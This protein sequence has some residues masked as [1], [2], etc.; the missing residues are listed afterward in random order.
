MKDKKRKQNL[1]SNKGFISDEARFVLVGLLIFLLSFIGIIESGGYLGK[2]ISFIFVYLFGVF[3]FIPLILIGIY[4]LYIFL[5][6]RQPSVEV[7]PY[8]VTI[9]FTLFFALIWAS[10]W[11]CESGKYLGEFIS[12][13]SARFNQIRGS[14]LSIIVGAG[15]SGV[16]GGLIGFFFFSLFAQIMSPVG[17][18]VV[19]IIGFILS[20]IFLIRPIIEYIVN[21]INKRRGNNKYERKVKEPS[22]PIQKFSYDTE[23]NSSLIKPVV[24]TPDEKDKAFKASDALLNSV[25]VEDSLESNPLKGFIPNKEPS[26]IF[27]DVFEESAPSPKQKS[28]NVFKDSLTEFDEH[29]EEKPQPKQTIKGFN[30]FKDPLGFDDVEIPVKKETVQQTVTTPVK[31]TVYDISDRDLYQNREKVVEEKVEQ[32]IPPQPHLNFDLFKK[33]TVVPSKPLET[34]DVEETKETKI[35]DSK[36]TKW[37]EDAWKNYQKQQ[38]EEP[39]EETIVET[40]NIEVKK[41]EQKPTPKKVNKAYK[42]PPASL[43]NEA[44]YTDMSQNQLEADMKA[45]LLN[46][47]LASLGIKGKVKDYVVAPAFTRFQIEVQSDVKVNQIPQ[48]KNDLMMALAASQIN[49]L[50]PIPGTPYVGIDIPNVQRGSVTFKECFVGLPFEKRDNKLLTAIGKDIIG[51]VV[52]IPLDETPHLLVAGSTGAGKSV[53]L[54]TIITSIIMRANPDEVQM[55]LIDPKRVEFSAYAAIPHLLCPVITDAKRASVALKKLCTEMDRRYSLLERSGKKNIKHYNNYVRSVGGD[56]LSYIVVIVDELGDLMTVAKAEVEESV[57]RITQLARAAGIHLIVATQR[58]SV[59]V[60]TGVI[61][62]NIP[63]RVAFAVTSNQDSRTILD[64]IGAEE[65]LGKGD[66]LMRLSGQYNTTRV[67][68]AFVTD[69]EVERVVQYAKSQ[70][71]PD[72]NPEFLNLD[73]VEVEEVNNLGDFGEDNNEVDLYKTIL[74]WLKNQQGVSTSSLQ[75]KFSLGYPRAARL[76]DTLAE[77]G[78]IGPPNGSKPREIYYEHLLDDE[79]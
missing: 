25:K 73:P 24:D 56:P 77:E 19:Y 13:Y 75:R 1:N 50:A 37:R 65:L 5:R 4:G 63:S 18:S 9:C 44:S 45:V 74:K 33:D 11:N 8:L 28:F 38:I 35:D 70:R 39:V 22:K 55:V 16:G 54:N 2:V 26:H 79:E 12:E 76:I 62:A 48:A 20:V 36:M 27:K 53:C 71:E 40:P 67:Q 10:S 7:G 14:G 52:S 69:E 61:K 72:Y 32:V 66:M 60:I 21:F 31:E 78:Y 6:R 51:K 30:I 47:K 15:R 41:E 34:D 58:P 49:I 17:A 57:R 68:G 42:L 23:D 43:L 3:Y 64:E 59:D 46:S 29:I